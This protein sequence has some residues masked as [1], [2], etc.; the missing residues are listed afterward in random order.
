LHRIRDR[1]CRF[2][3]VAIQLQGGAT[4][5]NLIRDAFR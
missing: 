5:V 2:D 4:S 3:V 1:A